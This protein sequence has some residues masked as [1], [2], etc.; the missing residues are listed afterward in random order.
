VAGAE[1]IRKQV[2]DL[3]PSDLEEFP[4]WEHAIDEEGEP[5]QD[6]ATVKPRPDLE[7]ADPG[8]GLL[9]ARAELVADDG[10]HFDGYVYPSFDFNFGS[11][12]P[13]IVTDVGQVNF[14]LGGFP[15]KPGALE[16]H[17]ALLEKTANDLFPVRFRAVVEHEGVRLEGDVPAFLHY[18]SLGSDEIVEV[19]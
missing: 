4:I 14:W 8:E 15:P 3:R 13:T 2:Y 1:T 12:Q 19:T 5:G 11:I 6:E 10:T 9:V 16:S 18:E 17:Y 7:T